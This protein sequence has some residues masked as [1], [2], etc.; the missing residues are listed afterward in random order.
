MKKVVARRYDSST[1]TFYQG[2]D[3]HLFAVATYAKNLGDSVHLGW[4]MFL[5]GLLHDVS[6]SKHSFQEKL[7][8]NSTDRVNH[9]SGGAVFLFH[10]MAQDFGMQS[11][12]VVVEVM[13]YVIMAHHGLFDLIIGNSQLTAFQRRFSYAVEDPAEMTTIQEYLDQVIQEQLSDRFNLSLDEICSLAYNE[14][15]AIISKLNELAVKN[16]RSSGG[17]EPVE[18]LHY[19]IHLLVRLMLS[20]LKEADI[21]DSSNTFSS[22]PS[23]LLS[24]D[25]SQAIWSSGIESIENLYRS[26]SIGNQMNQLNK[27]RTRIADQAKSAATNS[28][29]GAIK[30][31]LPTGSGKTLL[32]TR[33]SLHHN[34]ITNKK[35]FFYITAFL[36]VLEQNAKEIAQFFP[37]GSVLEHHSNVIDDVDEHTPTAHHSLR[38]YL[39][40]SWESPIIITTMVQFS[41]ALFKGKA[42]QLRRFCKLINSTIVIDEIQSLPITT[43]YNINLTTNFLTHIMGAT[44]VH[45][46]ATQPEYDSS[47]L[48]FPVV[49]DAFQNGDLVAVPETDKSV[50]QRAQ[51]IRLVS[52]EGDM[53]YDKLCDHIR[54]SLLTTDSLLFIGNTKRS[55][56]EIYTKLKPEEMNG[57]HVFELTTNQCAAHRLEK[58]ERIKQLL[59]QGEKIIL[60][61]TSIVEAGVDIDI[62]VVYR[63][64]ASVSSLVQ[65]MG[66]CNREGKR[67]SGLFYIV[68]LPQEKTASL[69]E[70]DDGI[71]ITRQLL[72]NIKEHNIDMDALRMAYY[73]KAY[74]NSSQQKLKYPIPHQPSMF[75]LLSV[76][77]ENRGQYLNENGYSYPHICAQ[78]FR[79]AAD[80]FQLIDAEG[81]TVVVSLNESFGEIGEENRKLIHQLEMHYQ[82][83]A[84]NEFKQTIR[85]LQRYTVNIR[86][87]D[88]Y[89]PFIRTVGDVKI[90][91][92][93]YY[94]QAIGIN[95]DRLVTLLV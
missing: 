32:T 70:I 91:L 34:F 20:M 16:P 45:C 4:A 87:L 46:T 74:V 6:K 39:T 66:R 48:L 19:Y 10:K 41:N 85:K 29:K 89:I 17:D 40:E 12:D 31:E 73:H 71:K 7:Y 61:S 11:N 24:L 33:F 27:V 37:A 15:L 38:L 59:R 8:T 47:T 86:S 43:T 2:L 22:S 9:S 60:C 54:E 26:F 67:D 88:N 49:F 62:H 35:R 18:S 5:I 36:S 76:N 63:T 44:I 92:P 94:D 52:D 80:Q 68:D 75:E 82:N 25:S 84:Y 28:F 69:P 64:L 56:H 95:T 72:H 90:L 1:E 79:T 30:A 77:Q 14:V 13:C 23:P 51:A 53:T 65:A 55:V 58:I 21:Y 93:D 81:E 78:S 3:D 57:F 50:F 42:S 83:Q